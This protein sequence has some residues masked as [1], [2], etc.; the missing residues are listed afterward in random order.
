MYVHV[1]VCVCKI[2]IEYIESQE[3]MKIFCRHEIIIVR[4]SNLS[5]AYF[6]KIPEN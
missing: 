5:G 4:S 6:V 1:C 3:S 2:M